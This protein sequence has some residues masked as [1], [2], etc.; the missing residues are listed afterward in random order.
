MIT[1]PYLYIPLDS[2]LQ[3]RHGKNYVFD[4]DTS[5]RVGSVIFP[6]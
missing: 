6:R 4:V 3:I 1:K 5:C 2:H